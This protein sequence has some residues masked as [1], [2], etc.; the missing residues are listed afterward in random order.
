LF[1]GGEKKLVNIHVLLLTLWSR[2]RVF[3]R[4]TDEKCKLLFVW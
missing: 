1:L 2:F 3:A 4:K